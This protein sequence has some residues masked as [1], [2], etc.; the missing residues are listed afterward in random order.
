MGTS[1]SKSDAGVY[2]PPFGKLCVLM[3]DD[4]NMPNK[5]GDLA[6]LGNEGDMFAYVCISMHTY[7]HIQT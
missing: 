3:V 2:G 7:K 5:A 6:S 1:H 4:L